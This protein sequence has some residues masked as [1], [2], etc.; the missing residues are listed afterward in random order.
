MPAKVQKSPLLSDG[1][2]N[3][4]KVVE[5]NFFDLSGKKSKTKGTS[6]K[7]YHAEL[8]VA[9]SGGK[10]QIYS[11]WGQTGGNQTKD[12]RHYNSEAE[13]EKDFAKIIKSKKKKGYVEID[14]AQRAYGSSEAKKITK[15][16]TLIGTDKV[17]KKPVSSLEQPTQELLAQLFGSTAQFVATT[18]K[19][20]LGQL[21]NAQ[22]DKGRDYLNDAKKIVN[23]KRKSKKDKEKLE[24]LTNEF[25]AAIPHNLGTGSRGQM[26]NLILDDLD[27]V[28][29]KESDLDTL[30]DAK[31][32]GAALNADAQVDAQ[33][34]ELG[35]ELNW[36]D[37][38]DPAFKFMSDYFLLSKVRG[39]GYDTA[40]VK[41]LWSMKRLDG[42]NEYFTKNMERIAK[43]CG[44]HSFVKEASDINKNA[45]LFAP[46]K[47]PDLSKD[48]MELIRASNTWLC[49]HGTRSANV[50]GISKKGLLIRPSGAIH[51]GSLLGDAKYFSH[52]SS[53]SLN[54]TDGGYWTG[55]RRNNN[56]R[57][58]FLLDVSL[59]N[60]HKVDG[61]KF[62][63]KPPK[64]FHSVYGKGGR[65]R[66]LRNDEMTT[67]DFTRQDTQSR[68]VYLFEISDS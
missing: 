6:N 31:S 23:K 55:G 25:Y 42:E 10:A 27:K 47:R 52:Q 35:A 40:R 9:K 38:Q 24:E 53:K 50:I 22:I 20:P 34:K 46:E 30:L 39:H 5:L 12:W 19:C 41:N 67:Y 32:V 1:Q 49:W 28:V 3:V 14:V 26:T 58:M 37:P 64:G 21:T 33:Y 59:G 45:H 16:V 29:S 54:Y 15:A 56:S 68:I 43:E 51:T 44:A 61:P 48:Q 57:F 66:Y 36:I 18:L 62:F 63:K 65:G 8:Q 13:A 60:M 2:F 4:S 17:A 7:S 11:M